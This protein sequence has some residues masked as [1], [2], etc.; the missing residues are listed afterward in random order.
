MTDFFIKA[1]IW[2]LPHHWKLTKMWAYLVPNED[3]FWALGTNLSYKW[4]HH[5]GET[6]KKIER[7]K[8][9][10]WGFR[11]KKK[12]LSSEF[13]KP[14]QEYLKEV[15]KLLWDGHT[16]CSLANILWQN[17]W[18]LHFSRYELLFN[19]FSQNFTY[20]LESTTTPGV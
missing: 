1:R 7:G 20:M 15:L 2:H 4:W 12:N 10:S 16:T 11:K 5:M 8:N 19:Q 13:T 3:E 6:V 9:P 14:N 18:F 17:V